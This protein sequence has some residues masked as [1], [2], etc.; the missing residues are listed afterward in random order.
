MVCI[1]IVCICNRHATF[2][3]VVYTSDV[4]VVAKSVVVRMY[5]NR[6]KQAGTQKNIEQNN[7]RT[8]TNSCVFR[9]NMVVVVIC[10]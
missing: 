6:K 4:V 3:C 2:L 5:G 10:D 8:R 7:E 1:Y 9:S